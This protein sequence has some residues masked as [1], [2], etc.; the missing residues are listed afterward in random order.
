MVTVSSVTI[1]QTHRHNP[2][3]PGLNH[4]NWWGCLE[5]CKAEL[6]PVAGGTGPVW[7]GED[8]CQGVLRPVYLYCGGFCLTSSIWPLARNAR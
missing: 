5:R 3:D 6:G 7:G 1:P 8:S 4:K 2:D